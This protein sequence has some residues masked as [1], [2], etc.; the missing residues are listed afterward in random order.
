[1]KRTR[2]AFGYLPCSEILDFLWAYLDQE[3]AED[4]QHEFD[5]H[6]A[7]CPACVAYLETYRRT[8]ALCRAAASDPD[9]AV[10]EL[11]ADLVQAIL[12]SRRS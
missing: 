6:L 4:D 12:A 11:P 8:I 5:S 7:V 9:E 2:T 10:A 3:L 1:M